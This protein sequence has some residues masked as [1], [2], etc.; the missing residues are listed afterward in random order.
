MAQ[1]AMINLPVNEE[2]S[3]ERRTVYETIVGRIAG[4][5]Q[6]NRHQYRIEGLPGFWQRKEDLQQPEEGKTYRMIL[7]TAPKVKGSGYYQDILRLEAT[8]EEPNI[9]EQ[10]AQPSRNGGG[11]KERYAERQD[12]AWD[13]AAGRTGKPERV[14]PEWEM[15]YEFHRARNGWI[16]MQSAVTAQVSM[17]TTFQSEEAVK[18]A[19]S[20][21]DTLW[22]TARR[23]TG[24][25]PLS[26]PP[27][28]VSEDDEAVLGQ[29]EAATGDTLP[30]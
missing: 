15:G 11:N 18:D 21:I 6:Y 27:E 20:M 9:P 30:W 29:E 12:A 26:R 1:A 5:S 17:A 7:G 16:M 3:S 19:Y 25:A 4:R 28:D 14:A 22:S 13:R 10:P 8:D 24:D 23:L 2:Q